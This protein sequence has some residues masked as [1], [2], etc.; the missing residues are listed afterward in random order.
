L[1]TLMLAGQV[2]TGGWAS[3]TLTV[4]EQVLVPPPAVTEKV[5]A[6]TPTGKADPLAKPSV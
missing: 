5:F 1:F 6:V 4:N 2:I 3:V